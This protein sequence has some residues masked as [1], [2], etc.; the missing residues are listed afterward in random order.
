MGLEEYVESVRA[1]GGEVFIPLMMFTV[2]DNLPTS[3][4]LFWR[5]KKALPGLN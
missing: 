2:L 3:P 4:Y 1:G 5:N